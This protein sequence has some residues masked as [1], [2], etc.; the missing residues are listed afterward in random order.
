VLVS[1]CPFCDHPSATWQVGP[2]ATD[3]RRWLAAWC[4]DGCRHDN[5]V[6]ALECRFEL[7]AA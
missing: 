2:G 3:A 6:R 4:P 7:V 5:M 1:R